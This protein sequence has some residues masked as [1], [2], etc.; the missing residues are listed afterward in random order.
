M[1]KENVS[2]SHC[3]FH[4]N[5][6]KLASSAKT[7]D[8]MQFT[9]CLGILLVLLEYKKS[10]RKLEFSGF[11]IYPFLFH[12]NKVNMNCFSHKQYDCELTKKL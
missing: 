4:K 12:G 1:P 11:T 7:I 2:K 8:D 3:H 6:P 10:E 9:I 5:L